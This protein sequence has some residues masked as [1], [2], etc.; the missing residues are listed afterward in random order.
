MRHTMP[1]IEA[2]VRQGWDR[3]LCGE[4]GSWKK[5]AF[6]GMESFGA[7]APIDELYERFGITADKVAEAA[8]ALL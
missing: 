2:A 3:W 8:K 4:H 6:V 5:S 7:S 1:G